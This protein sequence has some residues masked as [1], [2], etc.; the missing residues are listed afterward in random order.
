MKMKH[1]TLNLTT[2]IVLLALSLTACGNSA[3]MAQG[4]DMHD[5]MVIVPTETMQATPTE[6]ATPTV[7]PYVFKT[8]EPVALDFV[9][10]DLNES[11]ANLR[12]SVRSKFT[13]AQIIEAG[14][15]G[16]GTYF[17]LSGMD[18]FKGIYPEGFPLDNKY[19]WELFQDKLTDDFVANQAGTQMNLLPIRMTGS[20]GEIERIGGVAY[21]AERGEGKSWETT[22]TTPDISYNKV[23]GNDTLTFSAVR[24]D[25]IKNE[26]I[27]WLGESSTV[28][29]LNYSVTLTDV[30]GKW[31]ISAM[32]ASMDGMTRCELQ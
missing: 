16:L 18:E 25:T 4:Q 8:P 9:G 20:S 31:L 26:L 2:G 28:C 23:D 3:P 21:F 19:V 13:D 30:N 32:D 27:E 15:V 12:P 22:S 24:T 11:I 1:R 29:P 7:A 6:E 14:N 5:P 17:T 10:I